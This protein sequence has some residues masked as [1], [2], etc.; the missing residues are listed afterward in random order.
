MEKQD[1]SVKRVTELFGKVSNLQRFIQ[2]Y[3]KQFKEL[4]KREIEILTL[5]AGGMKNSAIATRL[6]IS[7][8]TV[9][10]HRAG[11]RKK[12]PIKSQADYIKYALAFGLI[13]F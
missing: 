7:R 11:I 4:S 10:N 6:E 8:A 9:Q 5:V 3:G 1:E 12:I 2:K 13:S